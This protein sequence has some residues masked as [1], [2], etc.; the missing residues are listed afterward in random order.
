MNKNY[1]LEK[2]ELALLEFDDAPGIVKAGFALSKKLPER[3]VI[4]FFKE[5]IVG[6]IKSGKAKILYP[7]NWETGVVNYCLLKYKDEDI[8][9][10]HSHVGAPSSAGMLD[11]AIAGG[12][13]KAVA[14]GGCGVLDKNLAAGHVIIPTAAIRDE[15]TSFHYAPAAREIELNKNVV[16][17]ISEVLDTNS[18]PYI[19]SKTWTTDAPYRETRAKMQLR[20]SEGCAAVDMEC[21]ALAAVAEYRGIEFGQ[22]LYSG[23]QLDGDVHDNR[24]WQDMTSTR[25]K[26]FTLAL[27]CVI[28]L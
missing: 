5:V 24:G 7:I 16:N 26:L 21:S 3:C 13:K 1:T 18:V 6:Y 9:I 11:D 14:C 22:L 10:Y 19:K 28:A 12:V 2:K 4:T 17:T 20:K 15:G 23:D 27:E 8:L 25:E